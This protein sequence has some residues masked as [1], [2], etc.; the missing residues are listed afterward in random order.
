MVLQILFFSHCNLS[1]ALSPAT[2]LNQGIKEWAP[3]AFCRW[4]DTAQLKMLYRW[5]FTCTN[6]LT[7]QQTDLLFETQEWEW[8]SLLGHLQKERPSKSE[9]A[10]EINVYSL[11]FL[12]S[13]P[14]C[15]SKPFLEGT[16]VSQ[17]VW[18]TLGNNKISTKTSESFR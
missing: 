1:S 13:L 6:Q 5:F 12:I 2:A 4:I 7:S 14:F 18:K 10:G 16:P 9:K 3:D 17:T 15:S 8:K 11:I